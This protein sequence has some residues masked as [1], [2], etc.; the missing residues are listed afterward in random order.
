VTATSDPI[1]I[2]RFFHYTCKA[3]L[4]GLLGSKTT[5]VRI[6]G[7]ISN[8][9]GI[10]ESNGRGILYLHTLIWVRGNLRFIRLRDRILADT[11]FANRMISYLESVVIQSLYGP[12]KD[13]TLTVPNSPP[14]STAAESD[15]EFMERLFCDSNSVAR[16]KQ[17]HSKRHTATY[18]KYRTQKS[19]GNICRFGMPRELLETS[20]V[21][22]HGIIHVARNHA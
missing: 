22:E 11:D 13:P 7:D 6:L 8:Y 21:D 12:N 20:K 1:T 4:N 9:F 3:V 18:F 5:D 17:L 2:A 15:A 16:T 10:V 19:N 14:T